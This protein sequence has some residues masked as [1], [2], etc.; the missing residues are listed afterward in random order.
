M[1]FV[2][3]P[4]RYWWDVIQSGIETVVQ[5]IQTIPDSLA[6]YDYLG[7]NPAYDTGIAVG[8]MG[9]PFR[10]AESLEAPTGMGK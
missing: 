8:W 10:R 6:F 4:S 2:F 5:T 1:W 3:G 9:Q 7:H